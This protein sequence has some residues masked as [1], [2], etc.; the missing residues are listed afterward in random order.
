LRI[1]IT[2]VSS[3]NSPTVFALAEG[4]SC[5]ETFPPTILPVPP[6]F[7]EFELLV[8]LFGNVFIV[9][10]L[11]QPDTAKIR[12]TSNNNAISFIAK[13]LPYDRA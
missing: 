13:F 7:F 11:S 4:S 12:E 10:P 6:G 2:A 3:P 9:L 1:K 8:P 5:S